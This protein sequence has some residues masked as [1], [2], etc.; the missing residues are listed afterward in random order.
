LIQLSTKLGSS[1]IPEYAAAAAIFAVSRLIVFLA[2]L[3]AVR[4]IPSNIP[5]AWNDGVTIWH[6]LL[7]WD[8]EWYVSIMRVGYRSLP[9]SSVP[10]STIK[11]FPL[12]PALS[13][14]IAKI[15]Q[16]R[17]STAALLVSNAASIAAA[18]LLY[19]YVREHYGARLAYGAVALFSFFPG[20]IFLSA[21]YAES[22]ATA[23]TMATFLDLGSARYIRA[24]CWCGLLTVARPTAIVMLAPL[25]YCLWPPAGWTRAALIRFLLGLGIACS[26]LSAFMVYQDLRFNAPLAFATVQ[27]DW[28]PAHWSLTAGLYSF[29][30]LADLFRG[31]PMPIT[32]DPWIF[33]GFAAVIFAMRSQLSIPELLFAGATFGFLAATRLCKDHSFAGV[34]RYMVVVFPAYIATAKMLEQR[35]WLMA[36]LCVF[37]AIGLFWYSAL[38]AQWYWVG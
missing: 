37:M 35:P 32:V 26:G 17:F 21:G 15:L 14:C 29:G 2:I 34:N 22:L 7:R 18:L 20:S 38:F 31:I 30:S 36:A 24:S 5:G 27:N 8:S 6:Y 4:F 12:Y 28:T 9:D 10:P 23:L 13:R 16:V 1:Q 25:A 11:F 19:R 33:V 3:F